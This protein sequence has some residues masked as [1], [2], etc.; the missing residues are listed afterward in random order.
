MR[1][2]KLCADPCYRAEFNNLNCDRNFVDKI[3]YSRSK[4]GGGG[5]WE[6]QRIY[7][8]IDGETAPDRQTDRQLHE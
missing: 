3:V 8:G 7:G 5:A 2:I 1:A 6:D 4:M